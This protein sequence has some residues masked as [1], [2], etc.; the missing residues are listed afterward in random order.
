MT[1]RWYHIGTSDHIY[2][3]VRYS[4]LMW[5]HI[6]LMMIRVCHSLTQGQEDKSSWGEEEAWSD[7]IRCYIWMRGQ[8][9]D[10]RQSDYFLMTVVE[11]VWDTDAGTWC[12][13]LKLVCSSWMCVICGCVDL[14]HMMTSS[15]WTGLPSSSS[16][17]L[18]DMTWLKWWWRVM[19]FFFF[20]FNI[21]YSVYDFLMW[22]VMMMIM[23]QS[24][25]SDVI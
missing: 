10:P 19:S 20:F 8:E 14:L 24:F 17:L 7:L 9:W 22:D 11:V 15:I 25:W 18:T 13:L 23:M 12:L 6:I 5:R 1:L 4:E 2:T 16:F 3:L 21:L